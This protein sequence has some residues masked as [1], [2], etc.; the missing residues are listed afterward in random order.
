MM[1]SI[2]KKDKLVTR[3]TSR[4]NWKQSPTQSRTTTKSNRYTKDTDIN[5]LNQQGNQGNQ[6]NQGKQTKAVNNKPFNKARREVII[7]VVRMALL[8]TIMSAVF[9]VE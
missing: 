8:P 2:A 7:V 9:S 6:G 5:S 3:T 4:R 1:N